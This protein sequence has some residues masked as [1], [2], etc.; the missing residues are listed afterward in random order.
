MFGIGRKDKQGKQVRIEHRGKFT[1]LS[2][3]K[4]AAVRAEKKLLGINFTV[5][6][7]AG[8][9]A[10]KKIT[11]SIRV[12]IQNGNFRLIG[13]WKSGPLS[14]NLSKSGFSASY[15]NR[16]GTFNF[17]KPK[18]SSFK[19]AGIQYRGKAAMSMQI[20]YGYYSFFLLIIKSL[21]ACLW[22]L[23]PLVLFLKDLVVEFFIELTR[24]ETI[25]SIEKKILV[26]K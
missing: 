23:I 13:R 14:L 25:N 21:I 15:K 8:I 9:R 22:Y 19:F 12:A 17:L 10:S 7:S 5:N 26:K 4:G 2:R 20:L 1:R 6:S 24:K 18:Y 16:M 3:T 11:K